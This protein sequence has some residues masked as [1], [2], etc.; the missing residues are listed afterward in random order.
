GLSS[1]RSPEVTAAQA[2]SSLS[3]WVGLVVAAQLVALVATSTR[4]GYHRDEMYF[5]AAGAHPAFGYPD[6]PPIVPLVTWAM[7]EIAPGSL[8]LLR[9]PSELVAATTTLL[10]A[11]VAREIGGSRRAQVI[12]AACTAVSGVA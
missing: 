3:P 4:Y 2:A 12:A 6:Q 5:I 8:L 9:L 7:Q 11:L 1:S 10:A